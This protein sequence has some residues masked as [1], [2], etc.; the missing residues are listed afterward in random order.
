MSLCNLKKLPEN[1]FN[2][3]NLLPYIGKV[4]RKRSKNN[5]KSGFKYATV[6]G[7]IVNKYSGRTGFVFEEDNTVVDCVRCIALNELELA[8]L[9]VTIKLVE[10]FSQRPYGRYKSDSGDA[11]DH[12]GETFREQFLVPVLKGE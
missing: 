3:E 5:F 9:D 10:E 4:I 6:E 8:E 2:L 1:E 7:I 12:S 11:E